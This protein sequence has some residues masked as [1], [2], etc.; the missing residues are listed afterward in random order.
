MDAVLVQCGTMPGVKMRA[1]L[2]D[3]DRRLDRLKRGSASLQYAIT[4]TQRR[5]QII[6]R[7]GPLL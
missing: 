3:N 1:I 6:A 7:S 2:H 4:G 5:C